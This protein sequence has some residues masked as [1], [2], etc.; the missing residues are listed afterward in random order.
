MILPEMTAVKLEAKKVNAVPAQT[1]V[2]Q[3]RIRKWISDR[4]TAAWPGGCW[5]CRRPFTFGQKFI[6]IRGNEVVVRF[7]QQCE[8]E[9]RRAQETLARRA[10]ELEA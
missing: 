6:D 2:D 5:H 9:W 3:A 10:L 7:H 8:I 1:R 4:L